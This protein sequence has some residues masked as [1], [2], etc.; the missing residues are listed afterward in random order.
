MKIA[1][2]AFLAFLMTGMVP[3]SA[4]ETPLRV[5]ST[6]GPYAQIMDYVATLAAKQGL[7]IKVIE[8]TDY[9]LP[10]E[11]MKNGDIDVSMFQT[12][13]YLDNA[14]KSRGYDIVPM[15]PAI[16]VPMGIYSHKIKSL[17]DLK[18][19]DTLAIPNDPSNGARGLLLM[20][21]AGL[22]QLK[23]GVTTTASVAD[24]TANPKHL[25]IRE[26]DAAQVPRSLDDMAAAAVNMSYALPAGLDPKTAMILEGTDTPFSL[27]W[28]APSKSRNDP[29]ITKLIGIY[30]SPE[31]KAF[32]LS[33]FKDSVIPNW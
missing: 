19:G 6:A 30:R 7:P 24:I 14:V 4:A 12:R 21:R 13:P 27:I 22:I 11:A 16:I 31:V 32:I 29:R 1:V 15:E 5:G 20:Q 26:L 18:D 2:A 23:E 33:T 25:K 17:S 10:N 3:A 28:T 9:A 8:F